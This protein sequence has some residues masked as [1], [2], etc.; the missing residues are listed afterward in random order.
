MT[1]YPLITK[2]DGT[3]EEF[4]PEKL[5]SSLKRSGATDEDAQEVV[6]HLI[7]EIKTGVTTDFIYNHAFDIL[8][9]KEIGVAAKYSLRRA[10]AELG[11]T[12]FPFERFVAKIHEALGH[13]TEVGTI[14]PGKCVE[15]EVDVI[16]H[17]AQ[18]GELIVS[19]A[20]FH[21]Q[22]SVKSDLKVVLYVKARFDDLI[23]TGV[24]GRLVAGEKAIPWVITN[25]KFTE[26]ARKYA[27]C[28]GVHL[29]GWDYPRGNSLQDMIERARLEP[30]TTLTTLSS[31]DKNN[32]VETGAVLCSEVASNPDILKAA[33]VD[34][35]K[36]DNILQEV[37]K[38]C[39]IQS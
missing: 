34:S 3:Q 9:K 8:K 1:T 25:T 12:G 26:N 29:V 37:H 5:I 21:N 6:D 16:A 14:V 27:E 31:E 17:D 19:E 24:G 20:K 35:Q 18:N 13:T 2:Q 39:T 33:G 22:S 30:I 38:V 23:Q 28:M 4:R 10:L 15:Y 32:L 36:Y 7:E 11:P